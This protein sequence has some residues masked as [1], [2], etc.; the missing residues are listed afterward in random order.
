M[1]SDD[2]E[3]EEEIE[4]ENEEDRAFLDDKVNEN[5]LSFFSINLLAFYHE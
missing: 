4:S 5:D 2:E 3:G 1:A